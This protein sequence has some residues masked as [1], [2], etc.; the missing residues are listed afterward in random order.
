MG[1]TKCMGVPSA[2]GK[3]PA[4][5]QSGME[6]ALDTEKREEESTATPLPRMTLKKPGLLTKARAMPLES[7]NFFQGGR[8][9]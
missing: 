4:H 1:E 3:I 7:G 5:H 6:M 8:R 2:R 9:K